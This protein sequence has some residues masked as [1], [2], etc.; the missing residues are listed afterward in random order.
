MNERLNMV[1]TVAIDVAN[2]WID[3]MV[4]IALR[5]IRPP[6]VTEVISLQRAARPESAPYRLPRVNMFYYRFYRA[7][8]QAV[9][10]QLW[11][12]AE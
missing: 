5:A 6:Q 2:K 1:L 12:F 3:S 4:G 11:E 8:V 7:I 10:G 9:L